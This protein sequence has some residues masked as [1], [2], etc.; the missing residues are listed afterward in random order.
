MNL[1]IGNDTEQ[2]ERSKKPKKP[3]VRGSG[4]SA[5][6]FFLFFYL[7]NARPESRVLLTT[8]LFMLLG[9]GR[10]CH[11]WAAGQEGCMGTEM[12]GAGAIERVTEWILN[13]QADYGR[14]FQRK[15]KLKNACGR[16]FYRTFELSVFGVCFF[17]IFCLYNCKGQCCL[18]GAC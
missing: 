9:W 10:M 11:G 16:I 3:G 7:S 14:H 1:I 4:G 13:E 18:R 15:Q 6:C 17:C 2:Q 12:T 8:L 5:V